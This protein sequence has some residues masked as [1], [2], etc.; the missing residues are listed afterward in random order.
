MESFK[1]WLQED[2]E[3]KSLNSVG[4]D[5]NPA[6]T[7]KDATQAFQSFA[8]DKANAPDISNVS[9][10]SGDMS[11]QKGL[12]GLASKIAGYSTIPVQNQKFTNMDIGRVAAREL[13]PQK[14][15]SFMKKMMRK[16]MAKKMGKK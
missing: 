8:A 11:R 5:V 2:V 9:L 13:W 7:A 3:G 6:G 16:M 12:M 10:R 4:Q 14:K 1:N 15:M